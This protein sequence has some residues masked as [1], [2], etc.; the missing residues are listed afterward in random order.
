MPAAADVVLVLRFLQ[1]HRHLRLLRQ[2]R[3]EP[4]DVDRP[5]APGRG[6][7]AVRRQLLIAKEHHAM[8]GLRVGHAL[9]FGVR[10][11][12]QVHAAHFGTAAPVHRLD[13][14]VRQASCFRLS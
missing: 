9:D 7:L 8:L 14:H 12:V 3:E 4:V 5:E 11:L 1:H 10:Q 2:R 13:V 6:Q